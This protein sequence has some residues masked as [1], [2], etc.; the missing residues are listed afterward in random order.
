MFTKTKR[1]LV[2][3]SLIIALAA[4]ASPTELGIGS[5]QVSDKDDMTMMYVPAGEFTM[6]NDKYSEE[7]VHTVNLD[8]YW[9]D[10]TEV[11]NAMYA[12]CISAGVCKGPTQKTS[13]RRDS[14]Y[15]NSQYDDYPVIYVDWNMAKAYCKWAGRRLPTEAEWEKAARGTD[16][17]TYPWGE[18]ISC[19]KVND[20]DNTNRKYCVGDTTKV[21]SYESGKSP[22]GLYDMAGNVEEWV[23]SLYKPYPY[24]ATDGREDLTANGHR[25]LRG[26]S[27]DVYDL[28]FSDVRSAFRNDFNPSG[29]FDDVGFR[30]VHG[31]SP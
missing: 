8:A 25:V 20:Y 6:G 24:S 7:P 27:W 9:I 3:L 2:N 22:Y 17:R 11:T 23:S 15:S 12:K 13:Y 21:G 4:C 5:T 26:G 10:Q 29:T 28:Y 18:G 19:D 1:Y 16:G 14:Y 31:T 30:C